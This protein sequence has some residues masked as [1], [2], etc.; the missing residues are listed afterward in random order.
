MSSTMNE[1]KDGVMNS[2]TCKSERGIDMREQ[3]I[4]N[5]IKA[6]AESVEIPEALSP[7]NIEKMLKAQK[8]LAQDVDETSVKQKY[9]RW[10]AKH[11][12]A[13][14]VALVFMLG[15]VPLGLNIDK[16][17]DGQYTGQLAMNESDNGGADQ[18]FA[19]QPENVEASTEDSVSKTMQ[20]QDAGDLY[21]VAKNEDEVRDFI[22]NAAEYYYSEIH[23]GIVFDEAI[24]EGA[25]E[26]LSA[27]AMNDKTS[28]VA[29]SD[30]VQNSMN[31]TGSLRESAEL[32][33]S[34]TNLQMAGVDESDIVKTNGT[35]IFVVSDDVV[36]IT[37][38]EN[39]AM[40]KVGKIVPKLSSFSDRVLEMYVD[41][42]R[43]VLIVQQAKETLSASSNVDGA[44][45]SN[46]E[47]VVE[48]SSSLK[49]DVAYNYL[50]NY[51]TVLYTYDISDPANPKEIGKLEQDGNYQT[52]RKID[53]IVYLFTYEGIGLEVITYGEEAEVTELLPKV[54]G[55]TFSYDSIYLPERGSQGLVV[56]SISLD[57]PD[58]V[59]D[60]TLILNNYVQIYV[61]GTAMYLYN[62][63]YVNNEELTEIAKFS[64]D[65]GRISAVAAAS[66]P[67]TIQDTFAINEYDGNLR[68]LTTGWG[69]DGRSE[70]ANQLYILDE[71]LNPAGRI[72][73][74]APG[75]SIYA[76][77]YFGDLAYFITYR[78]IDPLFAADL[79]DI[80]NPKILGE[81]E[82][83]GYSEYL[84]M[85]GEDKLLGIGYE[86]DPKDGSR[87]G[88]KLVMFDISNPAEL[89]IIDT[90]VLK[91]EDYSAALYE[92]KCV[93]ADANA[94]II[95]FTTAEYNDYEIDYRVYTFTDG[96]F[97]EE[98]VVDMGRVKNESNIRGLYIG[99]YF[100]IVDDDWMRSFH[101]ADA[102]KVISELEL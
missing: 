42:D 8:A 85:W 37:K 82:I 102:Y 38:V 13:A 71:A 50:T 101:R 91:G 95:G 77:R 1:V 16:G 57:N 93:L 48:S 46:A 54:D 25:E 29:P 17:N 20:K 73:D 24:A 59:V 45:Y 98:L 70:R 7:E 56:S 99:E 84:H 87:E 33:Y 66:V 39:G 27:G 62:Y 30:S 28:I 74:I 40:S 12:M 75:E 65:E 79:S 67:G 21:V 11:L 78:N 47:S 72:E 88:I 19:G 100:Y 3:D 5:K 34:T 2:G 55:E 81:L 80:N 14:A 69:L 49:M 60:K 41:G 90:V 51:N 26:D 18:N 9:F 10:Q 4:L 97:K 86:T 6:S 43:L 83:T 23:Y 36:N 76:A 92:Y 53:D 94:N 35:H 32:E 61:S 68:V 64:L 15:L 89:S 22:E 52:S 31:E 44:V 63:N 58:E 96:E